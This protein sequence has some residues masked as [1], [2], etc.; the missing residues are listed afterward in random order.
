MLLPTVITNSD[1]H[2][3]PTI[4][5]VGTVSHC[6]A[7]FYPSQ[8]EQQDYMSLTIVTVVEAEPAIKL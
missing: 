2:E 8:A 4:I 1:L 5:K 7:A 6:Q 3:N